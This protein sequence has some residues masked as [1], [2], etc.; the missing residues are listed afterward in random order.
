M[1]LAREH[2]GSAVTFDGASVVGGAGTLKPMS[3]PK[4]HW[5]LESVE[6]GRS[7]TTVAKLPG[8]KARFIHELREEGEVTVVRH[9]VEIDG[10]STPLI[11]RLL[12]PKLAPNL[13]QAVET[14]AANNTNFETA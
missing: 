4:V 12:G 3:G 13:R 8:A 7:F 5:T 2:C 1:A 11:G 9:A 14:L 6:P 10:W